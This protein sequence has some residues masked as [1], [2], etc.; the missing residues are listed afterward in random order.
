M[1]PSNAMGFRI[2]DMHVH[3]IKRFTHYYNYVEEL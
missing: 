3:D 1:L 2:S